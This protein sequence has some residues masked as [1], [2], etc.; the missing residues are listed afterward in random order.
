MSE[1]IKKMSG[2]QK[3]LEKYQVMRKRNNNV[4]ETVS[5]F[6]P[7]HACI[8][9]ISLAF[10]SGL[11]DV[12]PR[13][14]SW[15]QSVHHQFCRCGPQ[16][17]FQALSPSEIHQS[18]NSAS[19]PRPLNVH[20]SEQTVWHVHY[21]SVE[22]SERGGGGWTQSQIRDFSVHYLTSAFQGHKGLIQRFSLHES[23]LQG[24]E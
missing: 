4:A 11:N 12:R 20:L 14:E 5:F 8:Q 23:L 3:T 13:H 24:M 22:L 10:G 6:P 21:V 9:A 17:V 1:L 15:V 16:S 19:A 18:H 2:S 7:T